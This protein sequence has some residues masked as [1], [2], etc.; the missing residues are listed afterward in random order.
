M[1][2]IYGQDETLLPW[3]CERIGI[4]RFRY[5]AKAI[6]REVDGELVAVVVYDGF[7]ECDCNMHIA[8]NGSGHWMN[9]ELLVHAFAYPF[10]QLDLRRVT[11]LV[12]ARN[13]AALRLDAHLGFAY[14]GRCKDALPDDDLI[15]LGMT[16]A[17]C[18]FI[19]PHERKHHG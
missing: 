1:S 19:P 4:H 2:L 12:P 9:R 10:I 7:S 17:N 3:A 16:R 18:R 6:G 5:D 13:A 11:A 15:I 8:S 14:E